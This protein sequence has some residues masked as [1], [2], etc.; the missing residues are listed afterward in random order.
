MIVFICRRCRRESGS[1]WPAG[2]EETP[3]NRRPT[4]GQSLAETEYQ[5]T[6]TQKDAWSKWRLGRITLCDT[7]RS[8]A[9]SPKAF[10]DC[11]V[12]PGQELYPHA[13][14]GT[15]RTS[16]Y[17]RLPKRPWGT[18]TAAGNRCTRRDR[19][20]HWEHRKWPRSIRK[21]HSP[22]RQSNWNRKEKQETN[23]KVIEIKV[24]M[25]IHCKAE[26]QSEPSVQFCSLKLY[27][28]DSLCR[29]SR[30]LGHYTVYIHI[31]IHLHDKY[32]YLC[33]PYRT[34]IIHGCKSWI[35]ATIMT[36]HK[37]QTDFPL[38]RLY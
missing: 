27:W 16:T 5:R 20:G 7:L 13:D 15:R 36:S 24:R 21:L 6:W 34:H 26:E 33:Q 28:F 4:R 25:K 23:R 30:P 22:D 11:N 12:A 2:Q 8:L 3:R 14:Q 32:L 38:F 18:S 31:D 9:V 1:P 10:E 29:T 19:A 37:T 35:E 17:C